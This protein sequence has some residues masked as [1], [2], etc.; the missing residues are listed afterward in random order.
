MENT[1][2]TKITSNIKS[3][4]FHTSRVLNPHKHWK[5]LLGIFSLVAFLLVVFSFYLLYKIKTEQIFRAVPASNAGV[6][7]L[8]EKLIKSVTETFDQRALKEKSIKSTPSPYSDP[9]L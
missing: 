5:V 7:I 6:T 4:G 8:K 2:L 9:S 1:F 3:G